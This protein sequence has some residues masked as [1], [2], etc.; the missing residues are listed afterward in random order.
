MSTLE[1][2]DRI[3]KTAKLSPSVSGFVFDEFRRLLLT[4][5]MDNGRWCLPGGHIEPGESV[6]EACVRE[7]LEETGL[8][9]EVVR[10]L[11]VS[12]NP[13]MIY[14]YPDGNR[15]QGIEI[16]VGLRVIGGKLAA[17]DEVSEFGYFGL[18]DLDKIDLMESERAV[19]IAAL[20]GSEPYVR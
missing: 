20:S 16:D 7:I 9:T 1:F 11:G 13:H 2:G 5:R 18:D 4:R 12:S 8:Q 17:S 15:W 10:L 3:G 6:A 19:V 14:T